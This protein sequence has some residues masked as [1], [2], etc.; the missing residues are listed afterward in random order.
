MQSWVTTFNAAIARW[1]EAKKAASQAR[2]N[3]SSDAESLA[4]AEDDALADVQTI[5]MAMVADLLEMLRNATKPPSSMALRDAI[6][7]AI[8]TDATLKRLDELET[9]LK[10][11][12]TVVARLAVKV[13]V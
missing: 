5:R 11:L 4:R 3:K 10:E 13:G 2:M 1:D 12:S 7:Q 6:R 9:D 8:G